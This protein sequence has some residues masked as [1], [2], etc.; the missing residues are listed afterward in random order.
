L[1]L[2]YYDLDGDFG[3]M[4]FSAQRPGCWI[5][6]IPAS[7]LLLM[8]EASAGCMCAF[9]NM[10]SVVF[11][12]STRQKGFSMYSTAGPTTP[13]GRLALNLGAPGDR[14]DSSGD[15]WVSCPRPYSGRLVLPLEAKASFYPGGRF[16]TENSSYTKFKQ[17][18]DPW[19]FASEARGLRKLEIPLLDDD[20]GAA[21]FDVTLL[22]A[23]QENKQR[24]FDIKLQGETVV[25]GFDLVEAAGGHATAVSQTFPG[26][27]V[28]D[29]L[30]VELES[31]SEAM[32]TLQGIE[33]VRKQVLDL[34]C[35]VPAFELSSMEPMQAGEIRL[36]NLRSDDFRGQLRLAAKPGF[37]IEPAESPIHLASGQRHRLSIE[38]VVGEDIAA[39]E[40]PI[41]LELVSENGDVELT[42]SIR[43]EH[44]GRR[45]RRVIPASGDVA[46]GKRY[47]DRNFGTAAVLLVDGGESKVGDTGHAVALLKFQVD[48]PG[49]IVSARLRLHNAG[50]PSRD[51]GRVR[52]VTESWSETQVTYDSRPAF[53]DELARI[54]PVSPNQVV[55]CVLPADRIPSGEFSLV[56]DPVNADGIDYITR[57]GGQPP[58]LVLEFEPEE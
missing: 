18:E 44:L 14:N 54:G 27:R 33:V 49:R 22:F 58:S 19:L 57:E 1:N 8:P 15:L 47:P 42:R 52:L 37:T 11:K 36:A 26:I 56:I 41:Q 29:N 13:V 55:D 34:G 3:T 2:G 38:A 16:V 24:V 51:S 53:G 32:P 12:P 48:V 40:Y 46:I 10:C 6:F 50:N 30:V 9:P 20:D 4:H 43:V 21:L 25:D 35:A 39:G 45:G 5:N 31:K 28:S 7:G 23:E 17:T